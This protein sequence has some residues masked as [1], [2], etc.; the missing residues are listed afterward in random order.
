MAISADQQLSSL[1]VYAEALE[2]FKEGKLQ[3]PDEY[4]TRKLY[5]WNGRREWSALGK[6]KPLFFS[7]SRK[8]LTVRGEFGD[9]ILFGFYCLYGKRPQG[10]KEHEVEMRERIKRGSTSPFSKEHIDLLKQVVG[11]QF[12]K[13]VKDVMLFH[14]GKKIDAYRRDKFFDGSLLPDTVE[15]VTA[16]LSGFGLDEADK[17]LIGVTYTVENVLDHSPSI[18]RWLPPSDEVMRVVAQIRNMSIYNK[19][20]N[21]G[22]NKVMSNNSGE[23][24]H[25][26][27]PTNKSFYACIGYQHA[28]LQFGARPLTESKIEHWVSICC[29]RKGTSGRYWLTGYNH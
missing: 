11:N 14:M 12:L 25:S 5:D 29:G 10:L 1:D 27:D 4:I 28:K 26:N 17:E 16:D 9:T 15:E 23:G 22:L 21:T 19:V 20:V 6:P 18:K 13:Q 2:L 8:E 24:F 3:I 7:K